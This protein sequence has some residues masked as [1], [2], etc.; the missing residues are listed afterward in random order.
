MYLICTFSDVHISPTSIPIK[1]DVN[2]APADPQ[3]L[4]K[5]GVQLFLVLAKSA[6]VI[7]MTKLF[8]VALD[9]SLAYLDANAQLMLK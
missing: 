4:K 3:P 5:L 2:A 9:A 6:T 8:N 1:D 7:V